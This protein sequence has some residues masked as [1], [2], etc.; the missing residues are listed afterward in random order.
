MVVRRC[1]FMVTPLS[2]TGSGARPQDTTVDPPQ[3][4]RHWAETS[5]SGRAT[6][7]AP[8]G[9]PLLPVESWSSDSPERWRS[10]LPRGCI[11]STR[12]NRPTIVEVTARGG[13]QDGDEECEQ[14]ATRPP[15]WAASGT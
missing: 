3:R 9:D 12:P 1:P 2:R 13:L 15:P 8:G 10:R 11:V 5:D 14:Q 4:R 6:L 7:E